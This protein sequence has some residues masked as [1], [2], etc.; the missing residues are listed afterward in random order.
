[1][2][3]RLKNKILKIMRRSLFALGL[4]V[5]FSAG[6]IIAPFVAWLLM[7]P[8][9]RRMTYLVNYVKAADRLM[10]AQLGFSGRFT[11]STECAHERCYRWMHDMLNEIDENHCEESMYTEGA[12][13]RLSDRKIGYK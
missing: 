7:F 8:A 11:L 13:C 1:M 10:A 4:Y 12:Y 3:K 2:S 5:I 6:C 9:F